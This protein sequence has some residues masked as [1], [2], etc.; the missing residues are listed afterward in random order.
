MF[1]APVSE[2]QLGERRP[3]NEIRKNNIRNIL[4]NLRKD[5]VLSRQELCK[6]CGLTG[7]GLSRNIQKLINAGLLT[8]EPDPIMLGRLGRRRSCLSI[9][10]DGAYVFGITIAHN[11]KSVALLNATGK[12]IVEQELTELNLADPT[13][14]LATI[15]QTVKDILAEKKLD[16]N[17][18]LGASVMLGISDGSVVV[19]GNKVTS[20]LLE[21]VDVP[22]ID[23][24]QSK[25]KIPVCTVSRA[26]AL[27]QVEIEKLARPTFGQKKYLLIN[28]GL[29]LGTAF[30]IIGGASRDDISANVQISHVVI[31]GNDEICDCGRRGCLE[32]IGAGA[33]VVRCLNQ[34][35]SDKKLNFHNANVLLEKALAAANAGDLT[36]C[37][38]FFNVGKRFAKG[39]DAACSLLLPD[40]LFIAG[41][42]GRQKDYVRGIFAGLQEMNSGFTDKG[43]SIC[44]VRSSQASGVF[45]LNEFLFS[46]DLHLD[47]LGI[48]EKEAS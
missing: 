22:V 29:G 9:N 8:E 43:I 35:E 23:L 7:A 6:K 25:I 46:D 30:R 32:Q 12:V 20:A 38:T 47:K 45:A 3:V 18:V 2:L 21:W 42:V 26:G 14:A 5:K 1:Q 37:D 34:I 40:H 27:I 11:R 17:R 48:L 4:V 28:C 44:D 15:G 10:P 41:E 19:S 16:F 36:V 33:G 39:I 13:G 31:Q 24:F